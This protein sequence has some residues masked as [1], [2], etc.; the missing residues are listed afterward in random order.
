MSQMLFEVDPTILYQQL[1]VAGHSGLTGLTALPHVKMELSLETGAVPTLPLSMVV[2]IVLML[3][4]LMSTEAA[5]MQS[6]VQVS[7]RGK[8]K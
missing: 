4:L 1:M 2:S 7:R 6:C 5:T 8:S 3:T